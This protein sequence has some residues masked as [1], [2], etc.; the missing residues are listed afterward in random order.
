MREYLNAHAMPLSET[1]GTVPV[2]YIKTARH[3]GHREAS[4]NSC[5]FF[6]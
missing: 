6:I 1:Y 4:F 5:A 2:P 3:V